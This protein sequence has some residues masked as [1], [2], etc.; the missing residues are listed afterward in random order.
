MEPQ[1]SATSSLGLSQNQDGSIYQVL[2]E[3]KA[4]SECIF[5]TESGIYLVPSAIDLLVIDSR[6]GQSTSHAHRLKNHLAKIAHHFD[7][8]LIDAAAGHTSLMVN[9]IIAAAGHLIIPMDY[10]VFAYESLETFNVFLNQLA[11]AY[12]VPIHLMA[13]LLREEL[14]RSP[15]QSS[16]KPLKSIAKF[17]ETPEESVPVLHYLYEAGITAFWEKNGVTDVKIYR[18][19][20][21]YEVVKSHLKILHG[22]SLRKINF[23]IKSGCKINFE[24]K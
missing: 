23:S 6:F 7:V 12:H 1:G 17:W 8:I 10:G 18:L 9:T 20:Y 15:R 4:I 19:P 21:S 2:M 11:E 13:V 24:R 3:E 16:K 14:P 22:K 5:E